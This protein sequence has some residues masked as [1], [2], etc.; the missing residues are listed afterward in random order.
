MYEQNEEEGIL[1]GDIPQPA[2]VTQV[3]V[4]VMRNIAHSNLISW[5]LLI[6]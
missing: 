6:N 4:V 3:P 1:L 5:I 2:K